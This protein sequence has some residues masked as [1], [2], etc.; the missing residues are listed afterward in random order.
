[1]FKNSK[2]PIHY[3]KQNIKRNWKIYGIGHI[4]NNELYLWLVK[5]WVVETIKRLKINWAKAIIAIVREKAQCISIGAL[6]R[7]HSSHISNCSDGFAQLGGHGVKEKSSAFM[8]RESNFTK[9]PHF[10]SQPYFGQVWG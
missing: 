2:P 8:S 1:M 10:M 4:T 7:V 6:L 5:G 9:K 3:Y